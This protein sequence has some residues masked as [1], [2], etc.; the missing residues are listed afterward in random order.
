MTDFDAMTVHLKEAQMNLLWLR[1]AHCADAEDRRL[2]SYLSSETGW[3]PYLIAKYARLHRAFPE[4]WRIDELPEPVYW[5]ALAAADEHADSPRPW[6]RDPLRWLMLAHRLRW[7]QRQVSDASKRAKVT[8]EAVVSPTV[9]KGRGPVTEWDVD[10]GTVAVAG[11][12]ISG[13]PPERALVTVREV[14]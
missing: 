4:P 8:G 7:H 12:P 10:T 14:L 2:K 3:S 9:F 6:Q 5:A 1:A 11:L 13:R